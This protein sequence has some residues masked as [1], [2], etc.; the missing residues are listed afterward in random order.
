MAPLVA[1]LWVLVVSCAVVWVL[2]LLTREYSWVDRL[3]SVIPVIYLWIFAGAAGFS[4]LRLNLMAVVVTLW[5]ARLTFNFARKGGYGRGGEDYRWAVLRGRMSR[6]QFQLFNLFFISAYQS[7]ILFL[8]AMP[9]FTAFQH[10]ATP[11]GALDAVL[12]AL[13]VA[14]LVGET[15]ADQQQWVFHQ[16]KRADARAG[17]E[18]NLRFL[19]TGLFRFSRHPNFFFE[20]A[21]WWVLFFIGAVSAGSL[22]QWTVAGP[23]LL[24]ALF[25]GSTI[26][27]E[28]ITL[29]KYPEYADYRRRTSPLV[30]WFPRSRER[31]PRP[32]RVS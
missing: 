5:G 20:Q 3:W 2:S 21:Q 16:G 28:S 22:L 7:V 13:V 10:R 15:V 19:Q 6:A 24:T 4:D 30:P 25:I 27:T 12:L 8:I 32:A 31:E 11:F 26:F 14:L 1:S 18:S 9:A 29:S 23:V 17:R